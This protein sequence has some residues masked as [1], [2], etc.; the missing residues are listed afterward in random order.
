MVNTARFVVLVLAYRFL[1]PFLSAEPGQAKESYVVYMGSPSG[2]AGAGGDPEAVRASHLEMLS[3]IVPDDEQERVALKHSFHHSFEG[4]AAEL[5]EKEAAALAGHER[6][7]SVFRDRTLQLH[8]TRS[9]DFLEVQSGLQSGRLGRRASGD[10]IIGIV[11]TGVWPESPSFSDAG[12]REVPARW[13]GVCMEGPDFKKSNCNKKLI[14]ARY[15]S[16]MPESN[17]SSALASTGSPRDTVG[18]G[19]HTASTAAG[20]VVADAD[21]YGLARGA[22]KGGA[23]GSRVAVYRACSLGGCASSAVLKA[24]DDAVADGVDVVSVSIGMSSAFQS[25]FLSDPIALGAFHANQR[26]VLVVCSAGNDGPNPYTVVNT[27]PWI[28]TVA[29]SSIDRTFRSTVALGNGNVVKGVGINFS[30]HSLTGTHYPLVFGADAAAH[31]APVG[32]ASNCYPGSLDAQKVAGKIVVC[33]ATDPMVSRRVKKLVAEG[34]GARGL[35]LIDDGEKDVPLV[36]G[37]FAFSQVGV[38]AG[39]QILE[40]INSTKNPTAVIL[41]TEDV[42]DFKPAPV[43]ASFSA[44]GPGISESILKPDLMAPG[45]SILAATIP[46]ADKDDVPP[47]QK[48]SLFAIKSGTSMACPHVAGGAAFVKSAHPGWTP[49][50]VRSALMTTAT[51][52][53]NLGRPLASSTGAAATGHDMGAGEMSPLRA[54]SPGLVF[55]TALHDY[56]DFLC[57][58]GYKEGLVRKVSGDARFACPAGAAASPSPDLAAAAVNYPSISVPRLLKG[59]PVAVARTAINVGPSNATYVAAVEA[60]PGL[61]VRVSPDRLVFSKRWTTA[62]YE[63]SFSVAGAGAS[64]GYAHGAVTWSDG[65]HTVRTPFA[66][67]VVWCD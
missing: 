2:G 57:F 32:E 45:V 46:S 11:D 13:R 28:L 61:T 48:P 16:V 8:T 3:S 64:K 17:A 31:Y 41:P 47:G 10:V 24:I 19:T 21:Y 22:A 38:D 7:V 15:Y 42:K 33:V 18:H 59:K 50:M 67:N 51:T 34:S 6:V 5:T 30:N 63:V 62:R 35:V 23:P 14:G 1:V 60:P 9:W 40:Y 55:D 58:Y 66:V 49:S 29:A 53:N 56:L 52:T 54:L 65:A 4:F 27:A 12:M 25:D 43:V 26:G 36:A 39:A 20:A 37:G 44:R